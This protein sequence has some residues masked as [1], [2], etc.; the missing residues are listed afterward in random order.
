[1]VQTLERR[2]A[3]PEHEVAHRFEYARQ[4]VLS[5][6]IKAVSVGQRADGAVNLQLI[7]HH[8]LMG[9]AK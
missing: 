3:K 5:P 1:M 9:L 8:S 2:F 4:V 6:G 7:W